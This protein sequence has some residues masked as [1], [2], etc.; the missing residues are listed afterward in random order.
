MLVALMQVLQKKIGR[1]R[2]HSMCTGC[3]ECLQKCNVELKEKLRI[4][5]PTC[6]QKILDDVLPV[7]DGK[8]LVCYQ[9]LCMQLFPPVD[10]PPATSHY[11]NTDFHQPLLKPLS[12]FLPS[13]PRLTFVY[14]HHV[15]FVDTH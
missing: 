5:F 1:D 7:E 6:E 15:W 2:D 11:Q 3:S 4:L 10:P 9:W 13:T 8:S 12:L 14:W